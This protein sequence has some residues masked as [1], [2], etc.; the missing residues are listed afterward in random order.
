MNST[1]FM[2]DVNRIV[3]TDPIHDFEGGYDI[4]R[5]PT[6]DPDLKCYIDE[7]YEVHA[8][9]E[10]CNVKKYEQRAILLAYD[11]FYAGTC[12]ADRICM[13]GRSSEPEARACGDSFVCDEGA[14]LEKSSKFPCPAGFICEFAT[15]P[16]TKLHA[17]GSQLARLCQEGRY[18]NIATG[19]KNKVC[20]RNY[21]CPT[22]T[23]CYIEGRLANDG[24]LRLLNEPASNPNIHLRYSDGDNFFFFSDHEMRCKA[25]S[26]TSL[27]KR[28]QTQWKDPK[29]VEKSIE[30]LSEQNKL[31]PIVVKE[32]TQFE[33][34]CERDNKSHFIRKAME[35]K[36]CNC[37]SQ[38]FILAAVYRLWKVC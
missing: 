30:Y 33:E 28:F 22:G 11:Q 15:T 6:F 5:C 10:C 17:P 16:D 37:Y 1:L 9:G 12:E 7:T 19:T 14:S 27:Q 38:F 29:N 20:P 32:S 23:A 4:E 34:T 3:Y 13:E 36:D 18:C 25:A 8:Q 2:D 31:L 24:L 26:S 21:F 35:R